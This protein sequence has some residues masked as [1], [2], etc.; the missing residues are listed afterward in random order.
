VSSEILRDAGQEVMVLLQLVLMMMGKYHE[1]GCCNDMG[2]GISLT[3]AFGASG[4]FR[5]SQQDG[6]GAFCQFGLF[7]APV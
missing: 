6:T 1:I 4:A 2:S 3:G 7:W 5:H